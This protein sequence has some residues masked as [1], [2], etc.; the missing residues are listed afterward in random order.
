MSR[1]QILRNL[2]QQANTQRL[3]EPKTDVVWWQNP[4]SNGG[5]RLS[6]SAQQYLEQTGVDCWS[7]EIDPTWITPRNMLRMDRLIPVPYSIDVSPRPRRAWVT[8]WDSGQAM[9]I[10]LMGDF[11]RFLASLERAWSQSKC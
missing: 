9:T 4:R 5:L 10:E 7:F 1:D 3:P 2:L 11:D 6:K 8:I